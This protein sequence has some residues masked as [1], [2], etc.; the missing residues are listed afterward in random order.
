MKSSRLKLLALSVLLVAAVLR[1]SALSRQG[2][3]GFPSLESIQLRRWHALLFCLPFVLEAPALWHFTRLS[4]FGSFWAKPPDL[5]FLAS[6]MQALVRECFLRRRMA[7]W[8]RLA[9]KIAVHDIR[10]AL[11][12]WVSQSVSENPLGRSGQGTYARCASVRHSR[13]SGNPAWIP[14][15]AA[16]GRN[17]DGFLPTLSLRPPARF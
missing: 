8:L 15:R 10:P 16:L 9:R 12:R 7:I 4:L 5:G 17:D 2:A 1:F 13:E 11:G 14:A 6:V 3:W